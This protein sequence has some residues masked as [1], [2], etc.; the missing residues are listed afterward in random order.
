MHVKKR[1]DSRQDV[2]VQ[3]WP[4]PEPLPWP[5]GKEANGFIVD[6]DTCAACRTP[7]G[8]PSAH[9]AAENSLRCS[10]EQ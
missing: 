3:E 7:T 9:Q 1:P 6:E 2:G 4:F 8:A 10:G 5:L